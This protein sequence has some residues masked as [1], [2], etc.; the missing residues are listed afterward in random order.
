MEFIVSIY[1]C[2]FFIGFLANGLLG[3][4][5]VCGP[6]GQ[7]T[8][9]FLYGLIIADLFVCGLSGPA[10]LIVLDDH[11]TLSQNWLI[12]TNFIQS[13]PVSASNISMMALS[14]NRYLTLKN[15]KPTNNEAKRKLLTTVLLAIIWVS[16]FVLACIDLIQE[17]DLRPGFQLLNVV[18]GYVIPICVVLS[19]YLLVYFKLTTLSL[20]ARASCGEVPLPIP[21][22][23]QR[24]NF[25]IISG[26]P[27][28]NR[29]HL[30]TEELVQV[31]E[32]ISLMRRT[33][34]KNR[35]RLAN[36]MLFMA[37][38]FL[39]SWFPYII[40]QFCLQLNI[41]PYINLQYS[42]LLGQF[43][44][45]FNPIIY[46]SYNRKWPKFSFKLPNFTLHRS[47]SSTNEANLGPFNPKL[48]RPRRNS[49]DDKQL[50]PKP[51]YPADSEQIPSPTV[52]VA[53]KPT[54]PRSF[55]S[56]SQKMKTD[57]LKPLTDRPPFVKSRSSDLFY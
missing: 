22:F 31:E 36:S 37:I 13:W 26:L 7:T 53:P 57:R 25:I 15:F 34:L 48:V 9:P 45:V 47:A 21:M 12:F 2:L 33:T 51:C 18:V 4:K 16:A 40:S 1:G 46:W 43:P 32:D 39:I 23:R 50:R 56:R 17:E 20:R 27:Q 35:K 3:L 19:C 6:G 11:H 29:R 54:E 49:L 52:E 5:F 44:S 8:N 38:A 14:I 28:V 55:N 30:K 41:S 42:L 24:D 10:T